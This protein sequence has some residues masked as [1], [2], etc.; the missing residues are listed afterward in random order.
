MESPLRNSWLCDPL[1][2]DSAFQMASLWC[3]EQRGYVSLPIHV[4]SYRQFRP[5]F[6]AEGVTA[7]LEVREATDK[8]MRGDSTF[9]D[10]NSAVVAL[11]AVS[12]LGGVTDVH[13]LYV[14]QYV[15]INLALCA[16]FAFTLPLAWLNT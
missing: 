1:A 13:R 4:A 8:K 9:I 14:L 10:A 11:G 5:A 15:G 6:P 7:V 16:T 2:L 12:A 3:Y